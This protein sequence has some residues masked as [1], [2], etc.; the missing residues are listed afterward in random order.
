MWKF[1]LAFWIFWNAFEFEKKTKFIA[2]YVNNLMPPW[3]LS[4]KMRKLVRFFFRWCRF[5][6]HL[7]LLM[8]KLV[9]AYHSAYFWWIFF[10]FFLHTK[11]LC[12]IGMKNAHF[13]LVFILKSLNSYKS[14]LLTRFWTRTM[15]EWERE[16]E[17]ERDR[18]RP[19][20]TVREKGRESKRYCH[21][22]SYS[23]TGAMTFWIE[24]LL[25]QNA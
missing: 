5:F 17:T 1:L 14:F 2:K 4:W 13:Q 12:D 7:P 6:R 21:N 18:K 23:L 20:E 22:P 15:G 16:R 11:W 24:W 10:L 3:D 19:R 8:L 9:K 25:K